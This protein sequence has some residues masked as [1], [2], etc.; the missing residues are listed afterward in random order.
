MAAL[1]QHNYCG[2]GLVCPFAAI[3][4][5]IGRKLPYSHSDHFTAP[6]PLENPRNLP[7]FFRSMQA[8]V[9]P[10]SMRL[11]VLYN[12]RGGIHTLF[13]YPVASGFT[14]DRVNYMHCE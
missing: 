8:T 14:T 1:C 5:V 10:L 11:E 12:S 6:H 3:A 4:P 2:P 13:I 7:V 9:N